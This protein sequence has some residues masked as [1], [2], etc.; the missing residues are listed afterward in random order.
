MPSAFK[1]RERDANPNLGSVG[2]VDRRSCLVLRSQLSLIHANMCE[3]ASEK[4]TKNA[5]RAS[6]RSVHACAGC[7][8]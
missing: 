8:T 1:R 4:G 7:W 2:T 3:F 5:C 6:T